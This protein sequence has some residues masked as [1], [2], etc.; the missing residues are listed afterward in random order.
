ME[1][2]TNEQ[3]RGLPAATTNGPE[4]AEEWTGEI[5]ENSQGSQF[6]GRRRF[7]GGADVRPGAYSGAKE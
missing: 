1:A 3:L 5:L 6:D 2:V 4:P 7:E